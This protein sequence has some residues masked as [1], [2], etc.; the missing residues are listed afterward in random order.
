MRIAA[1][2]E[3]YK[4]HPKGIKNHNQKKRKIKM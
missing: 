3:Q 4:G 2:Q 1:A